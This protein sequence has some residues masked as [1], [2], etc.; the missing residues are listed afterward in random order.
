MKGS[1][2]LSAES[3]TQSA[4]FRDSEEKLSEPK[5]ASLAGFVAVACGSAVADA[6]AWLFKSDVGLWL[7]PGVRP[8]V[9]PEVKS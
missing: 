9:K 3:T 6:L 5:L 7:K 2:P 4:N 1:F 8:D